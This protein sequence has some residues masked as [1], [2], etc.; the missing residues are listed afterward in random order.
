[1]LVTDEPPADVVAVHDG[2]VAVEHDH[3][4]VDDR[5]PA[6]RRRAV[7]RDVDGACP[8]L[9]RPRASASASRGSSSAIST[10]IASNRS[11]RLLNVA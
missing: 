7:E 9:R 2:Q 5:R 11:L 4:V 8:A 6:Q 3:V 10:R 1:M